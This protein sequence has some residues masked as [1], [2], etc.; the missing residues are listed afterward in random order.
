LGYSQAFRIL[1]GLIEEALA[2]SLRFVRGFAEQ[3]DPL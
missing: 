3:G 1:F 2:F